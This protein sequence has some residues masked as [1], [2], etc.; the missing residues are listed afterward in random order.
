M[1]VLDVL[2]V[3]RTRRNHALEHATVHL[4]STGHPGTPLAG[5]S[6][7]YGF[8]IYGNITQAMLT[9]AAYDALYRLR[10][11]ESKLAIHP[12]CGTNYLTSGVFAGGAAFAALS[13]GQRR[14]R[15]LRLPDV[16]VATTLALIIAQPIGPLLQEKVT[17]LADMGD[18]EITAVRPLGSRGTLKVHYVETFSS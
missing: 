10:N 2:P 14:D 9:T 18:L 6:T 1:N 8:Y 15:W 3:K 7:P 11:G 17:T 4:I 12:G 13:F 16:F 5:R